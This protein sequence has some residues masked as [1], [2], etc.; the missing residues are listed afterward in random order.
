MRWTMLVPCFA[1]PAES[2]TVG[3]H[4]SISVLEHVL[5]AACRFRLHASTIRIQSTLRPALR[6]TGVF[7][8][9]RLRFPEDCV[10]CI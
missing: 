8:L 4:L 6:C 3:G 7:T 1:P 10:C 9:H 2:R 5:R